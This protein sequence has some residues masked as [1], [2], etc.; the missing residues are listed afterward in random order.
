LNPRQLIIIRGSKVMPHI[1]MKSVAA[2]VVNLVCASMIQAASTLTSDIISTGHAVRD[3]NTTLY[4][5][6]NVLGL[7]VLSLD[8]EARVDEAFGLLTSTNATYRTAVLA[9]PNQNW[10]LKLIQYLGLP[11]TTIK[12]REQD[13]AAPALT[14]T[15]KNATDVNIALREANVKTLTGQPIPHGS[16]PG[17]TS[18]AW[19][20]DPDG[21]MVEAVQRSGPADYFTVPPPSITNGPGMRY[22]IRGQLDL[23]L[24][25]I[26]HATMFYR[27]I[28]GQNISAG[29][30]PLIGPGYAQIGFLGSL[31]G[32][33]SNS[34]W[35][36]TTGN[37]N[38]TTR[39][40]Y[41]EYDDPARKA[42]VYPVH[43]AGI[44]MT[45][46]AVG[47]LDATLKRV[48]ASR[49]T[50]ITQGGE[51]VTID[52]TRSILIRDPSGY[53]VRLDQM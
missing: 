36:A 32:I 14:L 38:P 15:C 50:I 16:G 35:A 23:T 49:L 47:D 53:L 29:F 13:P 42:I 45:T 37:C 22:V 11:Q 4:F 28:L 40:E 25:N 21:Y 7:E 46:Y 30:E 5:Y 3:L 43:T 17:T 12:Q 1:S 27:D 44:G 20:Y 24:S 51:P 26:S 9:I 19:V 33:P 31:F 8:K 48:K 2:V 34:T 52:G 41:Y 10:T 6:H 39:C 18:T